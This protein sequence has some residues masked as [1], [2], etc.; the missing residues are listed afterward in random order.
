MSDGDPVDV[1]IEDPRWETTDL[2]RVAA[3]AA[4]AT[5]ADSGLDP[6]ACEIVVLGCGDPRIAALNGAFRGREAPTNVLAWPSEAR[7]PAAPAAGFL[8]DVALAFD[9]CDGE[10]REQGKPLEEHAMH[11]VAHAILH[12]L[13][14]DHEEE[15]AARLMEARE[16]AILDSLGLPDPYVPRDG[17]GGGEPARRQKAPPH[18]PSP[19]ARA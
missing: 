2:P 13:G 17:A 1:V 9:T 14:H 7:D 19:G 8:G 3:A 12:L 16:V 10:A 5:L 4:R 11:L 6:D 18:S 15:G